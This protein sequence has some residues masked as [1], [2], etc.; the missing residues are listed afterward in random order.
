MKTLV[1]TTNASSSVRPTIKELDQHAGW[2]AHKV[3]LQMA[4]C[5]RSQ[6][7]MVEAKV[8]SVHVRTARNTAYCGILDASKAFMRSDV[9]CAQLIARMAWSTLVKRVCDELII[10]GWAGLW[11]AVRTKQRR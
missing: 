6:S 10:E 1:L 7:R 4:P 8:L 11:I 5:V 3:I 9:V 2:I